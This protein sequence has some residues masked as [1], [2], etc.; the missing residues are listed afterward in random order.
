MFWSS[1]NKDKEQNVESKGG[2]FARLAGGLVKTRASFTDRIRN[3][4]SRDGGDDLEDR[5]EELEEILIGA[6]VG[7][8]ATM[9]MLEGIREKAEQCEEEAT[10]D[11]ILAWLKEEVRTRVAKNYEPLNLDHEPFSVLLIVGVNGVG[12]TTTIAKLA[13]I[14]Q[15]YGKKVLLV[16]GDTFR[17]GA[18][19]QLSI[20]GER[21]DSPVIKGKAGGDPSALVFDAMSAAKARKADLLIIDTAGRLHTQT[22]LMEELKKVRRVIKKHCPSAPHETFLILDASTGQNAVSQAE[23]FSKEVELTGLCMTKL[24]G[25]AKGG[26]VIN[27]CERLDLPLRFIGVGEKID[28]LQPFKAEEFVEALFE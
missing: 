3:L 20:W 6:D 25:T 24:D 11:D 23:T 9:A 22:N 15:A 13:S 17:A 2:W 16:A 4:F 26:I 8:E 5:L 12:K 18:I 1:S 28:D 7:V 14:F 21:V 27:I 19:E 10:A